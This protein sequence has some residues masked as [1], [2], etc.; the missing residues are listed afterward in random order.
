M[1]LVLIASVA[2]STML[3]LRRRSLPH[4]TL[5]LRMGAIFGDLHLPRLRR[6]A[7]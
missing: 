2:A 5:A 1:L 6:T 3:Y 7:G 4:R